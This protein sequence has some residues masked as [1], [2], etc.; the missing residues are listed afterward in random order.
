MDQ[1]MILNILKYTHPRSA[2]TLSL[3]NR[4]WRDIIRDDGTWKLWLIM[5]IP[6]KDDSLLKT[7]LKQSSGS[8]VQQQQQQQQQQ[9]NTP[10]TTT[11]SNNILSILKRSIGGGSTQNE[12]NFFTTTYK[13]MVLDYIIRKRDI[14]FTTVVGKSFS[15]HNSYVVQET[16]TLFMRCDKSYI[17]DI[18]LGGCVDG[19]EIGV[20]LRPNKNTNITF[21]YDWTGVVSVN[22]IANNVLPTTHVWEQDSVIR[23]KVDTETLNVLFYKNREMVGEPIQFKSV[24][25]TNWYSKKGRAASCECSFS[26]R[27]ARKGIKILQC[28]PC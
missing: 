28:R 7:L 5:Q 19:G 24:L 13:D 21:K 14:Q 9:N 12:L 20:T 15:F 23:C 16:E 2:L 18:Y 26:L 27:W 4:A 10:N 17:L 25:V 6:T 8:T 1:F 11:Q 3:I 22:H